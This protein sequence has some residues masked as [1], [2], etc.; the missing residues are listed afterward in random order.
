MYSKNLRAYSSRKM[1][2]LLHKRDPG[3]DSVSL[4][5]KG[6]DPIRDEK[7]EKVPNPNIE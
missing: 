5:R 7:L 3:A 6:H 2:N 1:L 4:L